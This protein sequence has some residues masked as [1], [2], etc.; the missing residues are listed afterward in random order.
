[1]RRLASGDRDAVASILVEAFAGDPF[2]GW[3]WSTDPQGVRSGLT[4]WMTLVLGR[5]EGRADIDVDEDGAVVWIHPD[6]PLE[7]A[8]YAAVA[9]LLGRQLGARAA[10]VMTAI[11]SSS[12]LVPQERHMTLMYVGVRPAGQGRGAGTRV[13]ADGLRHADFE[14]LPVHLNSTNGRN[15]PFYERLGFRVVGEA[16]ASGSPGMRVMW[17]PRSGGAT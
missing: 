7:S 12:P 15:V 9:E 8:D 13:V 5:L 11:A 4:E 16:R 17:R 6:R 14:G 2:F 10:E 3:V 1:M